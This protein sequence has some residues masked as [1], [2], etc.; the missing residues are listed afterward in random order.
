MQHAS[1]PV[2]LS[3]F[4][5]EEASGNERRSIISGKKIKMSVKKTK[6]EREREEKRKKLLEFLN[7]SYD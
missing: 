2:Q 5:D 7:D 6:E 4:M 3:K 1:G